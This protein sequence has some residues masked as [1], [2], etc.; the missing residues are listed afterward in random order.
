LRDGTRGL[1]ELAAGAPMLLVLRAGVGRSSLAFRFGGAN[2]GVVGLGSPVI[3]A[4]R[5]PILTILLE[6]LLSRLD[7]SRSKEAN[8]TGMTSKFVLFGGNRLQSTLNPNALRLVYR[9][10][11]TIRTCRSPIIE[12]VRSDSQNEFTCAANRIVM[13]LWKYIAT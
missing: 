1:E 2:V 5:S 8:H 6:Y 11:N 4:R 10:K 3:W 13:Y 12:Y 7:V 9:G